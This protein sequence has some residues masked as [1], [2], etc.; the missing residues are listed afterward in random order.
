MII[1]VWAGRF[2]AEIGNFVTKRRSGRGFWPASCGG[3][4]KRMLQTRGKM[5]APNPNIRSILMS[6][7]QLSNR[8]SPFGVLRRDRRG[9]FAALVE[10]GPGRRDSEA[11]ATVGLHKRLLGRAVLGKCAEGR[12]RRSG[13]PGRS[14]FLPVHRS[15]IENHS[16]TAGRVLPFA[17]PLAGKLVVFAGRRKPGPVRHLGPAARSA[18]ALL[19]HC[20]P[21]D[22]AEIFK[23]LGGMTP[24]SS[25][26]KRLLTRA[27]KRWK[28][29]EEAMDREAETGEAVSCAVSLD[30]V[31]VPLR[32]DGD[33]EAHWRE[34]SSGTVSFHG[35]NG[36][37]LKT[38]SFGPETGK[39]TALLAAEVAHVR[40]VRP[41]AGRRCRRRARQ[42][43]VSRKAPA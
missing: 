6:V 26:L 33:E 21:K 30:G 16:H 35:A 32:S 34:A 40:K 22:G 19:C 17:V 3:G 8:L 15:D 27:G 38:L 29:E 20:T 14:G 7:S 43:D 12:E 24:S 13:P 4:Q 9:A 23:R 41:D 25:C 5:L 28:A 11:F 18:L 42:L 1:Q 10:E 36:T 2:R 31:M 37:R 39:T